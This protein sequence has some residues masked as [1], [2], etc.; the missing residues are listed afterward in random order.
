MNGR[1]LSKSLRDGRRVYGTMI[2]STSPHWPAAVKS[3]GAD[4]VFID[5]E[6]IALRR[7]AARRSPAVSPRVRR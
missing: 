7:H 2:V 5:T 1:E 3:A 6:H 4:F